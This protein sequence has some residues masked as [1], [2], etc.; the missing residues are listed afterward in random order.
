L[1]SARKPAWLRS[2][3]SRIGAPL[4]SSWWSRSTRLAYARQC[5]SPAAAP[6]RAPSTLS[7]LPAVAVSSAPWVS[8]ALRV[9]TLMTPFTALEPH[10][11]PAEPL[12]TS[13]RSTSSS[14]TS[15]DSQNTPEKSGE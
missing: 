11:V 8:A 13:M 4:V 1:L 14:S 3:A 7:S 9:T 12:S 15:C 6:Q 5:V 10:S 2:D